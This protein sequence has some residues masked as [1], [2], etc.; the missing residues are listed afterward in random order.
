[1]KKLLSLFVVLFSV[2]SVFAQM[3]SSKLSG[4]DGPVNCVVFINTQTG[5]AGCNDGKVFKTTNAGQ[6]WFSVTVVNDPTARF[7]KIRFYNNL[8]GYAVTHN[9]QNKMTTDAGNTW[10]TIGPGAGPTKDLYILSAS[11][12]ITC[13]SNGKVYKTTNSGTNWTNLSPSG[14]SSYGFNGITFSPSGKGLICS[15]GLWVS[16]NQGQQWNNTIASLHGMTIVF[17]GNTC[18]MVGGDGTG[19]CAVHRSLNEGS[20]WSTQSFQVGLFGDISFANA[21]TGYIIGQ[22]FS[23]ED[24][25]F[26]YKTTNNGG[27]WDQI[28]TKAGRMYCVTATSSHVFMGSDSGNVL[29]DNVLIGI[30]PISTEVP[31][32][33]A[34]NQNYPNPFNPTTNIEFALTKATHV[35]LTVFN[36]TGTEVATLVNE[37]LSIGSYKVDFNGSNLASGVY[38]YKLQTSDFVQT[39]K[40]ILVK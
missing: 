35:K 15:E 28:M 39:K 25:A 40:M 38:F 3:V 29:R 37:K 4:Y 6:E 20:S 12:I 31:N 27:T 23:P 26:L 22:T 18:Y 9:G 19:N 36:S 17:N 11:S 16:T 7:Y 34:L 33:F 13:G 32:S 30:T 1:M 14:G 5:L 21:S 8:T 10:S 2:A 24:Q